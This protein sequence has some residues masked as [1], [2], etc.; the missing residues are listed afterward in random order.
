MAL[1]TP[2]KISIPHYLSRSSFLI[3]RILVAEKFKGPVKLLMAVFYVFFL[4][5]LDKLSLAGFCNTSRDIVSSN[6]LSERF[7]FLYGLILV[8]LE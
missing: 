1:T 3:L 2:L 8:N 4:C 6:C 7:Y 5:N